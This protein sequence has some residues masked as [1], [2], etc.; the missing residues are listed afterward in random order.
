VGAEP[1]SCQE[2][3]ELVTEYLDGALPPEQRLAFERHIAICPPC[4]G[5]LAEIRGTIAVAGELTEDNIP[6]AARDA[7]L[8]VF[9]S[10]KEG[11]G[12]EQG[13]SGP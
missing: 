2:L 10:W 11:R 4:R 5:Y 12:G 6:P 3:V 13:S 9:R 1:L 7:M 8:S